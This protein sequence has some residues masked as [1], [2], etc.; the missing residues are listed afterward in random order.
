MSTTPIGE[1]S[2]LLGQLTA[3]EQVILHNRWASEAQLADWK[4]QA[5]E[6]PDPLPAA[7]R[8][9]LASFL[10]ERRLLS[11]E[12]ANDLDAIVRQQALLPSYLLLRKLGSG[13]MGTVF[14]ATHLDS[15]RQVA[16][17]TMNARLV[18]D[19]DFVS[20]FHREAKALA[21]V[22]HHTIAEIIESGE[23]EGHCYLAMEYIPG[24]SLMALL[25]AHRVLP[26]AYALGI[27]RQVVDGLA[28]AWNT[29]RLVHRDIKP[30]NVLVI[31]SRSGEAIFPSTDQA[32]LIDFG[33]V[34]SSA[35]DERLTQTGMTIGT[36]LYM[37]PEQVRGEKLDCR[38]DIYGLG[39]TIYHLIT[40]ATPFLG[41]SPGAIMSAHLTEPVPDPGTRVP[42]LHPA[43]RTLVMTAMAKEADRRF[44]TFEAMA[45]SIDQVLA[46]L[47]GK[48][49][50]SPRLLRKPMVLKTPL[51]VKRIEE[52]EPR[53]GEPK[54][55]TSISQRRQD[56]GRAADPGRD[57]PTASRRSSEQRLRV[58]TGP[59]KVPAALPPS[60]PPAPD[61]ARSAAFADDVD[62]PAGIGL[63]PWLALGGAVAALLAYLAISYL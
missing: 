13:G 16:L 14:L 19:S 30:E 23:V 61:L 43:T 32:K 39:A 3:A 26:E 55:T 53:T 50:D 41:G 36:P 44:L 62:R 57:S 58:G 8:G 48:G 6:G 9:M 21:S 38:S 60:P 31:R 27:A 2:S 56:T 5:M 28:H 35:D 20:R 33:L 7:G 54:H 45:A 10:I 37:S 18:D 40:G 47:G 34:K 15:G 1:Q 11:R 42:S 12:L 51:A 29:A 25:K 24:Q 22:R 49:G 4:R 52:G 63:L 59:V 17:K 46:E